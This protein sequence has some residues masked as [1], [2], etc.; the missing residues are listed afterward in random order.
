MLNE[1]WRFSWLRVTS[2]LGLLASLVACAGA[3][4]T[5]PATALTDPS[6]PQLR[7]RGH[8][9]H[10]EAFGDASLPVLIVLHGGPGADYR[11]L[12]GLAA[13]A[14]R[15]RVVFYDQLGSGLSERVPAAQITVQS[16]VDD[17]DA[18]VQ[19]H[20]GQRAVHLLG[21]SWGAMLAT[22][23]AGAHPQ[24]V[25]SLVLAE[26]GFLDADS[27][28]GLQ[29][30]AWP[31]WRRIFGMSRAWLAQW[32]VSER[33][34]PYARRDWLIQQML[35]IAQPDEALCNGRLPELQGWR[36]G[37]PAFDATLGRMMDD[38]AFAQSL[39]FA[40]GVEHLRSPV[41]FLR[42]ACN[43]AQGE[44][45][46]RRMM[47]RFP[48]SSRPQLLSIA[49]A[50]HFMFNDQPEASMAAVRGFLAAVPP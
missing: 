11:Y 25:A 22:A 13:L 48:A 34:D 32:R 4:P 38:A 43:Q 29:G 10:A 28:A 31:G 7:L 23:Y 6:L 24:R 2:L 30:G 5:V 37:S 1:I 26:P 3:P 41:L 44:A 39:D 16:F 50:G 12:L 40:R 36:A 45:H 21:H 15:Y 14:D 20:A 47:A 46:Q 27:L 33:D 35:V 8:V 18:V 19:H 17:L 9:F 49:D 42:G